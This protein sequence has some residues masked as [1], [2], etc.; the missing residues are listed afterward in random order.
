[1]DPFGSHVV[2]SLFVLLCPALF[3]SD[4]SNKMQSTVRSK[5]STAWKAKQGPMKSVFSDDRDRHKA[6]SA[7]SSP[8][9]F[10][11]AAK[12]FVET[13]RAELGENEVRSLA[14]NKVA[15][16]VLQVSRLSMIWHNLRFGLA[17]ILYRC[18][19]KLKPTKAWQTSQTH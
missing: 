18:C 4:A 11:L 2:R 9:Q 12:R 8:E 16:P 15:S 3:S 13:V 1:M 7:K 19:W 5:K 6:R 14:A 10:R 17:V